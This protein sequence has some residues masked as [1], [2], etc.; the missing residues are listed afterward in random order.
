[1]RCKLTKALAMI[2]PSIAIAQEIPTIPTGV[3]TVKITR[4]P[5]VDPIIGTD[6]DERL[7]IDWPLP[8]LVIREGQ[9][10]SM[11]RVEQTR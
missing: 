2:A 7:L 10:R 9:W 5:S 8:L 11:E 6:D 1:M 4:Y 3:N